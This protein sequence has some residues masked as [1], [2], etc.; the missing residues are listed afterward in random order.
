MKT[1]PKEQ[2]KPMEGARC[3][4]FRESMMANLCAAAVPSCTFKRGLCLKTKRAAFEKSNKNHFS[5]TI[6]LIF[7]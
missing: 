7:V 1:N 5:V 3:F 4:S 6:I 2:R